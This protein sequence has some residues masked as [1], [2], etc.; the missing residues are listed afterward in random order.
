VGE[1]E[2]REKWERILQAERKQSDARML[3]L[4]IETLE[5]I[6][7]DGLLST[8]R[9]RES[10]SWPSTRADIQKDSWQ[11]GFLEL[12]NGESQLKVHIT[13]F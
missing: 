3:Q 13:H 8:Q 5:G 6:V 10:L 12:G 2:V 9:A 4:L 7:N 1:S 11:G